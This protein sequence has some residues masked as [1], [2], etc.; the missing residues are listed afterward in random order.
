M[1]F[2]LGK[3]NIHQH[4][5]FFYKHAAPLISSDSLLIPKCYNLNAEGDDYLALQY[6]G[7]PTATSVPQTIG[8]TLEQILTSVRA[9]AFIHSTPFRHATITHLYNETFENVDLTWF[10]SELYNYGWPAFKNAFLENVD[11]QIISKLEDIGRNMSKYY[12]H[13]STPAVMTK[14]LAHGDLW[15]NNLLFDREGRVVVI[16]WQWCTI[17]FALQDLSFLMYSSVNSTVLQNHEEQILRMY[18]DEMKKLVPEYPEWTVF[19][20]EY[21]KARVMGI[22]TIIASTEAFVSIMN[23]CDNDE[24]MN[25]LKNRLCYAAKDAIR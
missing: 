20:E 12:D 3:W 24:K 22:V 7:P 2:M 1:Q 15:S 17:G 19:E 9:L 4:E 14:T 23:K 10:L 8:L 5:Y 13:S 18:F 6:L 21:N 11:E 25:E 16:D